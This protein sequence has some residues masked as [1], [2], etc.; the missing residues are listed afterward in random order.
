M[1]LADSQLSMMLTQSQ[2]PGHTKGIGI[3]PRDGYIVCRSAR[4]SRT[5]IALV[6]HLVPD[7]SK[8]LVATGYCDLR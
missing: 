4:D 7:R 3:E 8:L 6:E 1:L 2:R 5:G